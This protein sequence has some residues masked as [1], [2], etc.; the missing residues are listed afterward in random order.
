MEWRY[1]E[2]LEWHLL[3]YPIH[4]SMRRYLADLNRIYKQNPPLWD[5]D[6]SWEGFEWVAVDDNPN[7]IVAFMRK[8]RAGGRMLA[9][10]NFMPE[11][12]YGYR[13]YFTG[14]LKLD[15]IFNSDRRI[16]GGSG[17]ENGKTVECTASDNRDKPFCA[18]IQ[19]PPLSA[20]YFKISENGKN[21]NKDAKRE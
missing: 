13:L 9:V 16:Y 11:N 21:S 8:E 17:M 20:L 15:E 3:R 18:T 2:E 5:E 4:D 14:N 10:F 12:H 19:I 7:G 6:H 1:D